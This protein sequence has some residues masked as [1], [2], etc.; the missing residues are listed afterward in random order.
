MTSTSV[1]GREVAP[2]FGPE[3]LHRR[4]PVVAGNVVVQVLPDT[5]NAI[6]IWAIGRQ[7]MEYDPALARRHRHCSVLTQMAQGLR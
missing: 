7:E 5:L 1:S 2:H 6:V 4:A 3:L